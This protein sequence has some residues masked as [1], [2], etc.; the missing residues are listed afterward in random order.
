MSHPHRTQPD[1][2]RCL[3]F[4]AL[5][6]LLALAF[7]HHSPRPAQAANPRIKDRKAGDPQ[8][9]AKPKKKTTRRSSPAGKNASRNP[10]VPASSARN[11]GYTVT[12][13]APPASVPAPPAASRGP[14]NTTSTS[15]TPASPLATTTPSGLILS[16]PLPAARRASISVPDPVPAAA[17]A[18]P[19]TTIEGQLVALTNQARQAQ[20]LGVLTVDD[21]LTRAAQIQAT[22]MASFSL[23]AHEIPA[24]PFPTL[25]SRLASVGY[26]FAWAGEILGYGANGAGNM[27]AL[28]VSSPPHLQIMLDPHAT[29]IGVAVAYDARGIPYFCEVFGVPE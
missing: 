11:P 4:V 27:V 18:A 3:R 26:D 22:A 1:P 17:P 24:A 21:D 25:A 13:V 15:T 5:G 19:S 10:S 12:Y 29:S 23:M 28:W 14:D 8:P 7:A 2:F 20:G 6:L 16:A 9:K